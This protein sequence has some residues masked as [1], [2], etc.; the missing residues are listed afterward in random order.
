MG[1]WSRSLPIGLVT[2]VF[3]VALA[4]TPVGIEFEENVA[5]PWLFKIRGAVEP[6]AE[7]VIVA[8]DGTTGRKLGLPNLPR[9]W[10]RSIH[11]QLVET[12]AKQGAS[13]IVLDLDFSQPSSGGN[14]AALSRAVADADRVVLY[15]MLVGKKQPLE[16]ADGTVG[17]WTWVEQKF[18]PVPELA[19]AAKALGSFP[20]PKLGEAATRF[21]TFKS[22]T[23][24]A[25]T[26]PSIAL[27]LH[28]LPI[29]DRWL[30]V[31]ERA[32]GSG[33]DPM[34]M[35]PRYD[36]EAGGV[37]RLM[38][39]YRDIFGKNPDLGAEVQKV[40]VTSL[41][42]DFSSK[43]HLLANA[44][45]D[46]YRGPD[47]RYLNFYGPPGTIKAIPYH[48][49][50]QQDGATAR[51]RNLD[52]TGKVVFV[53]Y[54]DLYDPGQPDRFYTVF[55]RSDGVDLSGVE[56][57]ATAFANLLTGR[58]LRP[59][60]PMLAAGILFGL[61]LAI[62]LVLYLFPALVAVPGALALAGAYAVGAQWA[63][64][65][66]NLWLPLAIPILVQ[67]P[68]ALLIGLMAQ[69]LLERHR[70]RGISRAM[71][72][73][74]PSDVVRRASLAGEPPPAV[75]ECYA[76]LM[77]T[78][79][80]S[81]TTI[82]EA[83]SPLALAAVMERYWALL[84]SIV[85]K[86]HRGLNLDIVADSAMCAWRVPTN[87]KETGV[88]GTSD[89]RLKSCMAAIDLRDAINP[90]YRLG[91]PAAG[92]RSL[93]APFPIELKT[94]F[95]LHAGWTAIGSLGGGG[96]Y[97]YGVWGDLPNTTTRIEGL[98][99]QLGTRILASGEAVQGLNGLLLRPVG[100]YMFTNKTESLE[101]FEVVCRRE[102]GT[103]SEFELCAGFAEAFDLL[104]ADHPDKAEA[105]F[106]RLSRAYPDDRP[107][108]FWLRKIESGW[109]TDGET[110]VRLTMK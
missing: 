60:D 85:E 17:G 32:G 108:N 51:N 35:A 3:G 89:Q 29:H 94:R 24:D 71:A 43:D 87:S 77:S 13:V 74:L 42:D 37:V 69:Y 30:E 57:M 101:I 56:I 49:L 88:S 8:I 58:T 39:S 25:P 53:G 81:Y 21:W 26:I 41:K 68:L 54:A 79:I 99:K 106:R 105:C 91:R 62:G 104:H 11:G 109:P 110:F 7:V 107:T 44:L 28:A 102:Q 86:R 84:N 9:N 23:G 15:E 63:F 92:S 50:I 19:A 27:Q 90:G 48:T 12:L 18:P 93:E 4:V 40:V 72:Y 46:L 14:D 6:P 95:G 59:S 70:K 31:L 38:A 2:A 22:S 75:E 80:E 103:E 55:S 47:V 82:S 67:L 10:P 61:G 5:L 83:T 78:D 36:P 97:D 100:R 20:L 96:H 52:L 66:A 65:Q 45:S 34:A 98:N 1:R 64:A 16:R 33:L 76:A 73:Y